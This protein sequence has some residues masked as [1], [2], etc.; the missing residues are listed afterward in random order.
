MAYYRDGFAGIKKIYR[1][2]GRLYCEVEFKDGKFNGIYKVYHENRKLSRF[3]W[4]K[5]GLRHGTCRD[6]DAKERLIRERVYQDGILISQRDIAWK[7]KLKR[8]LYIY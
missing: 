3:Y 6:Y 5:D 4:Y 7:R 1:D 8:G 2:N